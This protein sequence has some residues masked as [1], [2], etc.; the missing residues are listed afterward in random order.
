MRR[1]L[2]A[3]IMIALLTACQGLDTRAKRL[4]AID[5]VEK[6]CGLS[7]K[8]LNRLSADRPASKG[9]ACG[10]DNDLS[11]CRE[12]VWIDLGTTVNRDVVC[13]M[14]CVSSFTSRGGATAST[15]TLRTSSRWK[16]CRTA[17]HTTAGR[18]P[19][20]QPYGNGFSLAI[21]CKPIHTV[22]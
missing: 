12:I 19:L 16:P 17:A 4:A 6:A 22:P 2:T 20:M 10:F 9:R 13:R 5:E 3:S 8:S 18:L 1:Q 15:S 14:S 11:K 21:R 7:G